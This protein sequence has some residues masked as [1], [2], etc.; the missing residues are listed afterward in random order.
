MERA[1]ITPLNSSIKNKVIKSISFFI[2]EFGLSVSVVI[3]LE[4]DNV[5]PV[6]KQ[7]IRIAVLTGF[8]ITERL[9]VFV[10]FNE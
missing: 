6:T 9:V 3:V 1:D 5:L 4:R 7:V 8:L 10:E 2:N